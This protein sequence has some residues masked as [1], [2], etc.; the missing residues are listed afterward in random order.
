M[1]VGRGKQCS[2]RAMHAVAMRP[3]ASLAPFCTVLGL[4]WVWLYNIWSVN[5]CCVIRGW[6]W[7]GTISYRGVVRWQSWSILDHHSRILPE[8]SACKPDVVDHYCTVHRR[9]LYKTWPTAR[10]LAAAV[11]SDCAYIDKL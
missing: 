1:A 2:T 10:Q 4:L 8:V 5:G 7:L 9:T 6:T 11:V 3:D